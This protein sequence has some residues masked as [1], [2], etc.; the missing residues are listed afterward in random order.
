ML[1]V[2]Q[3]S[4]IFIS[5]L[6]CAFIISNSAAYGL[7]DE[8]ILTQNNVEFFIS[9]APT[10]T[11]TPDPTVTATPVP[12]VTAT[13]DPTVT[14]TPDPTVTATPD[15]TVTATPDPTVTATPVPTVTATPVPTVTAT[16]VPTVTATPDPT[17]TATPDPTVTATPVPTPTSNNIT[18]NN[19][20]EYTKSADVTLS[21][22]SNRKYMSFKNENENWTEWELFTP[23]KSWK[24]SS[25]DGNKKVYLS[26]CNFICDITSI[27]PDERLVSSS[28][29]TLDTTKPEIK[30]LHVT[31]STPVINDPVDIY[32]NVNDIN[33]NN[34]NIFATVV[35]PDSKTNKC[36]MTLKDGCKFINT[37]GYGRYDVT[38]SADDKAGNTNNTQKTWF[39]TTMKPYEMR[40]TTKTN[41]VMEIDAL[42]E[43]NTTL[44]LVTSRNVNENIKITMSNDTPPEIDP[45]IGSIR[46]GK[47][48]TITSTPTLEENMDWMNIKI[49]YTEEEL[50]ASGLDENSLRI[51]YFNKSSSIWETT[52]SSVNT[53]DTGNF[54]GYVQANV[55]HPGTFALVGSQPS[56]P[57]HSAPGGSSGGGGGG[58]MSGEK[59]SNIEVVEKYDLPI[60]K[61]R[62]TSYSFT[63]EKN[64]IIYVNITGNVSTEVITTSIEVLKSTSMLVTAAQE[65]IVYKNANIWVGL[66]GFAIPKNIKEAVI[67]FRVENSWIGK[68]NL[69]NSDIKLQRWDGS[70]WITLETSEKT[71]DS[72]YTF[73]EA[74]TI[75]FSPFAITA[76]KETL[77]SSGVALS[78]EQTSLQKGKKPGGNKTDGN[79]TDF[80][81]NWFLISGIFVVIG[82][83]IEVIRKTKK[84]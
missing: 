21:L 64:P 33:L 61:D 15:P 9:A 13:P 23:E 69:T 58:G 3:L 53:A 74:N 48:I 71:K 29:I 47:F 5:M 25:G 59:Y 66:N 1:S 54:S 28:S 50:K 84:K 83:I 20:A 77:T 82:L 42:N 67:M 16:P 39:I 62:T 31:P 4:L 73:F 72:T 7:I 65:G 22:T 56:Q 34:S 26:T 46:F 37:S 12:T 17:V 8:K 2:H 63:N 36:M 60:Y 40:V 38:I 41:E 18:I 45:Y 35:S 24:L 11:F 57:G 79:N 27:N 14:A 76:L 75:S 78:P 44:E 55:S 51:F 30:E 68:N 32:A 43:A 10:D 6:V 70:K 81:M 49:Y 19:G 80:L 52:S